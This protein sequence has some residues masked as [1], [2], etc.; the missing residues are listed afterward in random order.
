[1]EIETS[2]PD[3]FLPVGWKLRDQYI[4]TVRNLEQHAANVDAQRCL[5]LLELEKIEPEQ[6]EMNDIIVDCE[7]E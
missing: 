6:I 1:M 7:N 4:R 3:I 5:K 2:I